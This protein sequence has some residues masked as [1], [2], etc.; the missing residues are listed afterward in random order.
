MK[1]ITK[2][3][4]T[5][6]TIGYMPAGFDKKKLES[7]KSKI[8]SIDETIQNYALREDSNSFNWQFTDSQLE[9]ILPQ[10]FDGDFLIA[11]VNVPLELNWYSRRLNN[12]RVVFTFHEI[13]EILNFS[14]IPLENV[15][16]RL[17]Y[18]YTLFYFRNER[19]FPRNTDATNFTHD[20]TRGC[21]FDMNGNK[22]DVVHSCHRPI[23]CPDCVERS[24]KERVS[25]EVLE[26]IKKEIKKIKKPLFSKILDFIKKHPIWSLLISSIWAIIL[27]IIGSYFPTLIFNVF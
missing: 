5:I 14:N 8:F 23:V 13:K 15:I 6:A 21:L 18:A 1:K 9:E 10:E 17:L 11:I 4:I 22:M 19:S 25:N 3:K 27:G 12:N 2:T 26:L 16:F 24:K 20:E 7:Y